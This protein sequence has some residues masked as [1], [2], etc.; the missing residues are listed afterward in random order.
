MRTA[1]MFLVFSAVVLRA[2]VVLSDKPEFFLLIALL[3]AYGLLLFCETWLIHQ[4]P[5][6]LLLSP[7]SQLAYL[8]LQSVLVI[9]ALIISTYEDFLALLFIPL[10][11]DALSFFGR[12]LG[13]RSI[14]VFS[15][16]M[17]STLLSSD[18]GPLFGLAMGILYSGLCFLF[19]GYAHQV[20][21]AEAARFQNQSTF[22]ELQTAHRQLQG[23]ADQVVNLA[24]EHERNNWRATCTIQSRRR[25]SA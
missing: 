16:A 14:T 9:G 19:G 8:F 7:G 1:G 25:S 6:R 3:A 23:Y 20:Q 11:L 15:L 21:K 4:K 17:I 2:A 10:S 12:R 5:V 22:N 24:V 18:E 13:F